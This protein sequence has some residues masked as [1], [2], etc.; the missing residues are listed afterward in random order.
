M[1]Q[2]IL[3][4]EPDHL[5]AKYLKQ[6]LEAEEFEVYLASTATSAIEQADKSNPDLVLTELS[7]ASHSGSEFLYELRTYSD[8]SS[9]PVIVYSSIKTPEDIMQAKDWKLLN[10]SRYLYKPNDSL[11]DLVSEIKSILKP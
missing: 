9:I 4:L 11:Q 2:R 1:A 5:M 3:V 10:I 7:L 6:A 8:F